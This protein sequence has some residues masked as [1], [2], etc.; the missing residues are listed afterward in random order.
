MSR[1]VAY[2]NRH[3]ADEAH[4]AGRGIHPSQGAGGGEHLLDLREILA[5]HRDAK[6]LRAHPDNP[7]PFHCRM[8]RALALGT[9]ALLGQL[10]PTK[11]ATASG[12]GVGQTITRPL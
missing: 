4:G 6:H 7:N 11:L 10:W 12:G 2:A 8:R 3:Q 9:F 1:T 5:V